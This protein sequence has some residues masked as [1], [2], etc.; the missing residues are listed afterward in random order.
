MKTNP[1]SFKEEDNI[2]EFIMKS[3]PTHQQNCYELSIGEIRYDESLCLLHSIPKTISL[4]TRY[5]SSIRILY[6]PSEEDI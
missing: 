2:D 5:L 6:T 3:F 1:T 4:V